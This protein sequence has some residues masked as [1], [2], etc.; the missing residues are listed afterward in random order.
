MADLLR[1]TLASKAICERAKDPRNWPD[2]MRKEGKELDIKVVVD[3]G[4]YGYGGT[5]SEQGVSVSGMTP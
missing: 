3:P 1:R 4:M 2:E 5:P